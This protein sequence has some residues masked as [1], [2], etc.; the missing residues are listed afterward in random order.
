[1]ASDNKNI[2][3]AG[4]DEEYRLWI[5][6]LCARYRQSQVKAAVKVNDE[7]LRFYWSVGQDIE[8]KQ[9]ANRYGSHFFEQVSKDLQHDLGIRK[10]LAPNSIRYTHRFYLLYSPVF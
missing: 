3:A 10:G 7:M 1:M 2:T 5:R 6:Q 8:Q 4:F 9:Y